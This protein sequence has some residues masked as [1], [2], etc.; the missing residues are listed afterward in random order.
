MAHAV[1]AQLPVGAGR[2]ADA[3]AAAARR[4]AVVVAVAV[5]D[6]V[7]ADA[8][9]GERAGDRARALAGGL[10]DPVVLEVALLGV[11]DGG[12]R[13]QPDRRDGEHGGQQPRAQRAHHARGVRRA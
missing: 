3:G 7:L 5:G 11:G 8:L 9:L 12:E 4:A 6:V 2:Q 13:Q 10:V 1:G